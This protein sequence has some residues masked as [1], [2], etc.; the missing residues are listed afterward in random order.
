MKKY[1]PVSN[2]PDGIRIIFTGVHE[3]SIAAGAGRPDTIDHVA[4]RDALIQHYFDTPTHHKL[5]ITYGP[6][7]T[8]THIEQLG[9]DS[10]S[11]IGCDALYTTLP[12]K[13]MVLP[14]A[15][16]IA[17]VVYDPQTRML[18]VLHLGRH[19][20][21]AGLIESFAIEVADRVGSDPR[22]WWVWM[23]PSLKQQ[24]DSMDYLSRRTCLCG[25]TL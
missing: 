20:S 3:G 15:D 7:R 6:E 12:G 1:L 17:T 25:N 18:G 5:L 2:L 10:P 24:N 19:S 23:S 11:V 9:E 22:D 4:T 8:Y 16:C 13:V 14:V 21:I